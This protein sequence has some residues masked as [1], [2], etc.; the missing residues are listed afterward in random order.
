VFPLVA[1]NT[2]FPDPIFVTR[3]S[4]PPLDSV[5]RLLEDVWSSANLT[6]NGPLVTELEERLCS[7]LNVPHI[8]LVANGSLGLVL[9]LKAL[10][11]SGEVITTPFTFVATTQA[12]TWNNLTPVFADIEDS[13]FAL[14][15]SSVV[16]RI[17]NRTTAIL[18]T[19]CYGNPCNIEALEEIADSYNLKIIYDA[20]HA[21]GVDCH[22][23]S[24]LSHGDFSVLSFHATKVFNTF[25][26]GAI[27]SKTLD[28]KRRIDKLR[29]FG[30]VDQE[31][32]SLEGI[33]AKMSEFSAAVGICQ[34]SK[35]E[36][37]I[38]KR[39]SIA[40]LYHDL[41]GKNDSLKLPDFRCAFKHN[42]AY[43]P[44]LVAKHAKLSR[45]ALA[46]SLRN[47]NVF[48][49]KYF[50]PL[51]SDFQ[52]FRDNVDEGSSR[53]PVATDKS[54]SVLCLPIYPDLD[55]FIV[56]KVCSIINEVLSW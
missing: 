37:D 4:L 38:K 27:I 13:T 48:C 26:G 34:L 18:A 49:R 46:E 7:Y 10:R 42:Y 16:E 8:S 23:G 19:H 22:C 41:L 29:N 56:S 15:P 30:F 17:T 40:E 21:F 43:Y 45:D 44:I 1:V 20:A 32:V 54:R 25:E 28:D 52:L 36:S 31:E 12:L 6:N 47:H 5:H 2:P 33:N 39:R 9:A 51:V 11:L 55:L 53:L 3:P 14:S 50:Y 24:L 35:I